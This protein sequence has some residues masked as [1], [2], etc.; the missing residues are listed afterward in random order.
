MKNKIA[1][2]LATYNGERFIEQ[3][4]ESIVRQSY[5]NWELF[6]SDDGSTDDTLSIL[7]KYAEDDKRI[8]IVNEDI[9][10]QGACQNFGNLLKFALLEE[11]DFIMFADQDDFW[12]AD[13]I[14]L[15]LDAMIEEKN[16]DKIPKL[17]YSDFDYADDQLRP[18]LS[19]TDNNISKWKEL[20]LPRLLAQNNIYG[21]TMM[22]N[23]SLAE[24][25]SPIPSCAENHDYWISMVAA[26]RGNIVHIKKRTMLYRQHSNNF[27]GHYTNNSLKKRFQRYYKK[28]DRMEKIMKGRFK[29]AEELNNRFYAEISESNQKLLS[30]YSNF[31]KKKA[32][33]RISFCFK[34]GIKKDTRLQNLA[35]YYLLARM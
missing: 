17:I 14:Q 23:R 19:E 5:L 16:F 30:G 34:N 15:T 10:R 32:I 12:K 35:F 29:M 2:L 1:I 20:N 7:K 28:N 26:L 18:L 31:E 6:I 27:S 33:E 3:Q 22:I 25:V 21:C 24:D 9:T 13:K 8:H 11:W 4:L